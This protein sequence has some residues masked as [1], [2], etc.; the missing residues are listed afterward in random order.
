MCVCSEGWGV[1]AKFCS[2]DRVA[3][4]GLTFPLLSQAALECWDLLLPVLSRPVK[5]PWGSR[6][7]DR[8]A[9][10]DPFRTGPGG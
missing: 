6:D 4:K 10:A 5:Q 2:S 8:K 1:S 9:L 7:G 3:A